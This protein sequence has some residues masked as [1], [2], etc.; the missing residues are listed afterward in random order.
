MGSASKR[1]VG[2]NR[3]YKRARSPWWQAEWY[4]AD[5]RRHQRST[6]TDDRIAALALLRQW[7]RSAADPTR[8]A[9]AETTLREALE[10]LQE[11][12]AQEAAAGRKSTATVTFVTKKAGHPL[13]IF[14]EHAKL[15][16]V[17]AKN[18][19]AYI[20]RRRTEGASDSTVHKELV[21]LRGACALAA[22]RGRW[23]GDVAKVF[24]RGF[25]P[26][27]TPKTRWLPPTEVEKLLEELT[28][29]A[30]PESW[31][32]AALVAFV[33]AT[34]AEWSAVGRARAEDVDFGNG[35]VRVRG[36]KNALRDRRV[37]IVFTW[38]VQLLTFALERARGT[39]EGLLFRP[40]LNVRRA[41]HRACELAKIEPCSP[42]DL[43]RTFGHWVRGEGA[44][45]ATVGAALGHR[46]G[47]MAERVYAA[48]EPWEL[49]A[50]LRRE[51]GAS[52]TKVSGT[53]RSSAHPAHSAHSENPSVFA[54][55]SVPRDGI[56]PPTRGFSIP[57]SKVQIRL[58]GSRLRALSGRSVTKVSGGRG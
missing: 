30:R 29:P 17:T 42:H 38:Q 16:A 33:V 41:L 2:T 14:G 45:P 12:R 39:R 10:A 50:A 20:A 18:V 7:E 57:A 5:G 24:P 40:W 15:S 36:S 47:R 19:D 35:Y 53:D 8:A 58:P 22:R 21:V 32:R 37:P 11:L 25:S 27:Y 4:D 46:D 3:I 44:Q 48:L 9:S 31:D 1:D 34:G 23:T 52:V 49:A 43:R 55:K 28:P 26:A 6:R 54:E 56:E 13:R 51:S